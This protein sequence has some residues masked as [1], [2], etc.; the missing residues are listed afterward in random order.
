M[1]FINFQGFLLFFSKP[2]DI[3]RLFL[4]SMSVLRKKAQDNTKLAPERKAPK[5]ITL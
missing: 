3:S 1:I 2:V 5:R 4:Y